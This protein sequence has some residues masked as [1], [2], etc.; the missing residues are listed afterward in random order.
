MM[1]GKPTRAEPTYR[2]LLVTGVLLPVGAIA[3][4]AAH[5]QLQPEPTAVVTLYA[6]GLNNPRGLK[7][8]PDGDLYVAEGGIGG[9]TPP[10]D[11]PDCVVVPPVGPYTGSTDGAR[12]SKI[13]AFGN[14]T[15]VVD[16][17]P[18]SQTS[19]A[20]GSFVSGVAD[21]A[22]VD[23]TL[24]AILAGAGCSH[25]VP[26][27]PNSIIRVESD[28]RW[29]VIADLGAFQ[30]ANPVANPEE[31]DFEPDGTWYSMLAVLGDLYAVEPNHGEIVKVTPEGDISRVVDISASLGHVVPTALAYHGN[32]FVGNLGVFPQDEGSSTVWKVTP[33]G[34]ITKRAG[35]FNMVLGLAIDDRNRMYVLE[36]SAAPAPTGG[37]GRIVRVDPNGKD[38]EVI[39]DDLFLPTGMTLGPDGNLYISHIGFGTPPIGLGQILK[40]EPTD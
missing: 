38:R 30:R 15:T 22:F 23:D 2:V 6:T 18:S 29:E 25:G 12:I 11:D 31:A 40:I 36:T 20:L 19:P 34:E 26:E 3:P 33:S 28:G 21:V 7:F 27:V 39:A 5:A 14:R 9:E 37:T 16:G 10:P 35:G 4:H 8:G 17:L 32:F 1:I 24:Y 13:D